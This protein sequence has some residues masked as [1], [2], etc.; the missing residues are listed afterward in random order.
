M[1]TRRSAVSPADPRAA[2]RARAEAPSVRPAADRSRQAISARTSE[3]RTTVPAFFTTSLTMVPP[4]GALTPARCLRATPRHRACS[5]RARA[6]SS[7]S[8]TLRAISL[9]AASRDAIS[10]RSRAISRLRSRPPRRAPPRARRRGAPL[11]GAASTPRSSSVSPSSKLRC[12]RCGNLARD[13]DLA[14]FQHRLRRE[15]R[16]ALLKPADAPARRLGAG[17]RT[18][19]ARWPA[20]VSPPDR[21]APSAARSAAR[22]PTSSELIVNRT[23]PGSTV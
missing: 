5:F 15:R 13:L 14:L 1:G 21:L 18:S 2:A 20:A 4:H 9:N 10:K 16:Q 3:L 19:A 23:A 8:C 11:R 22:S 17:S 7:S 6:R 12:W